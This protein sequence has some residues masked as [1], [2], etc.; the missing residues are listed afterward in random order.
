M[1]CRKYELNKDKINDFIDDFINLDDWIPFVI[2][3]SHPT[4]YYDQIHNAQ[5]KSALNTKNNIIMWLLEMNTKEITNILK[6]LMIGKLKNFLINIL[7]S[8]HYSKLM[9][10][11]NMDIIKINIKEMA[12]PFLEL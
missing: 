9:K 11:L 6:K 5:D 7:N 8:N 2:E 10:N 1:Q 12:I 4:L 3:I